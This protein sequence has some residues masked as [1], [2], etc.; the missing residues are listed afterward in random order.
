MDRSGAFVSDVW[1]V[2]DRLTLNLG[3]RYDITKSGVPD[4][5]KTAA[6]PLAVAIGQAV[7][8]PRWA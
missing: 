3:V 6:D 8:V 5:A 7:M 2:N 4:V 1:R